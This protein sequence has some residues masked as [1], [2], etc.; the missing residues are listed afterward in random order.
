MA[1][2]TQVQFMKIRGNKVCLYDDTRA[3]FAVMLFARLCMHTVYS[4]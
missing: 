3:C 1:N 2:A 4:V